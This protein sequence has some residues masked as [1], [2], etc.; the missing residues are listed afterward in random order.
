MSYLD[1]LNR[2]GASPEDQ[3]QPPSD[4][5][6]VIE[7]AAPNAKPVHWERADGRIYGPAKVTDLAKTGTGAHERFWVIIEFHGETVWVRDDRL[8]SKRQFE[9]QVKPTVVELIKE[10]RS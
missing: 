10:P 5:D 4:A 1:R 8:R 2:L 6:L 7:P 3:S 9:I